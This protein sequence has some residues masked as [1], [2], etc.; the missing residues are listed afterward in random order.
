MKT[1]FEIQRIK[2]VALEATT[3][4]KVISSPYDVAEIAKQTIGDEDREVVLVICLNTHKDVIAIHKAHIGDVDSCPI[5]CKEIFKAAILNSAS[6]IAISHNHPSG[7]IQESQQD[8]NA[9]KT[10]ISAG[11]ILDIPVIDHVIVGF[12]NPNY[13]SLRTA[14]YFN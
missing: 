13:N 14:G 12:N 2:Q 8:I 6:T 11:D 3:N 7:T 1:V 4:T 9:T 5:S 10:L